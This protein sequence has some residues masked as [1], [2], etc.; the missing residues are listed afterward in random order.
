MSKER[1]ENT[2]LIC[3]Y[4]AV[5]VINALITKYLT[6]NGIDGSFILLNRGFVCFVIVLL[7]SF[8]SGKSLRPTK[9]WIQVIRFFVA[10]LSLIC[11]TN[12]FKFANAATI[13][14]IQRLEV[15]I[16]IIVSALLSK[17]LLNIRIYYS[18]TIIIA[19]IIFLFHFKNIG[20]ENKG[21][22]LALIGTSFVVIG[23]FLIKKVV[24][25]EN[26]LV[27]T[28]TSSLGAAIFGFTFAYFRNTINYQLQPLFLVLLV[29]LGVLMFI[30][31]RLTTFV[32][33]KYNIETAQYFSFLAIV[34]IMPIEY[35]VIGSNMSSLYATGL[36]I[37]SALITC[38]IFIP[39][40]NTLTDQASR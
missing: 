17:K 33:S 34:C 6:K 23:Y 29:L 19:A 37:F 21:V 3:S 32:Y 9:P 26:Y 11:I 39:V 16:V 40:E 22:Y 27:I 25:I 12:S 30:T 10:G 14:L 8:F 18:L 5:L 1:T 35:F 4:I 13:S 24:S 38:V 2:L 36:I 15:L 31:Y 20:E 28:F 7:T